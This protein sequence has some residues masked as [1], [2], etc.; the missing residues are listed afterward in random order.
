MILTLIKDAIRLAELCP[1]ENSPF[2][3]G[4]S[5]AF[6]LHKKACAVYFVRPSG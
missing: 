4:K 2:M 3:I 1:I 6:P 5:E